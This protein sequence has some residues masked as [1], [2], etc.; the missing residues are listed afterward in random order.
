MWGRPAPGPSPARAVCQRCPW[1][2][3]G[4]AVWRP[5]GSQGIER[6]ARG[7][8]DRC[9]RGQQPGVRTHGWAARG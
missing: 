6:G 7:Q 8:L 1:P 4:P 2:G 9:E 3:E 5:M